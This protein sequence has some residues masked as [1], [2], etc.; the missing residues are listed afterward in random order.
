M[1]GGA[2][3]ANGAA[4]CAAPRGAWFLARLA[5]HQATFAGNQRLE[6]L[7]RG[8]L[9]SDDFASIER[10][11]IAFVAAGLVELCKPPRARP[12]ALR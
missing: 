11:L 8:A 10:D 3:R 4:V 6:S 2:S 5:N 1:R 9:R 12:R 7:T